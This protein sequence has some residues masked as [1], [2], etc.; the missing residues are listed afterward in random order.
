MRQEA[1]T[2]EYPIAGTRNGIKRGGESVVTLTRAQHVAL[3]SGVSHVAVAPAVER[4]T[5]RTHRAVIARVVVDDRQSEESVGVDEILRYS[6]GL[7]VAGAATQPGMPALP[8]RVRLTPV[9]PRGRVWRRVSSALRSVLLIGTA[10]NYVYLRVR[11]AGLYT[12]EREVA[13]VDA[14]TMRLLGV[15]SG[16][17]A[18]VE[19]VGA[20]PTA[21]DPVRQI[22]SVRL[23]VV[24]RPDALVEERLALQDEATQTG[25][26][27]LGQQA[28]AILDADLSSAPSLPVDARH[29]APRDVLGVDM[30]MPEIYVDAAVR[31]KLGV[32]AGVGPGEVP[33]LLAVVRARASIWH[34]LIEE[35]K[36][37]A[38]VFAVAFAGVKLWGGTWVDW[39]GLAIPVALTAVISAFRIRHA[40]SLKGS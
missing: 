2:N 40:V 21:G 1:T 28:C 23:K 37:A 24:E 10:Q 19:G 13:L 6:L 33:Q 11:V 7:G 27:A 39:L 4:P 17:Y 26:G 32:G 25:R 35:A 34:L 22:G 36:S 20:G 12:A 5:L 15:D 9:E 31:Q 16:G 30:E 29:W 38:L 3:G 14:L 18:V 8:L